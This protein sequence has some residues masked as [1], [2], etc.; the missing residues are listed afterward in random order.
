METAA[1]S[2]PLSSAVKRTLLFIHPYGQLLFILI[3][4]CQFIR[5]LKPLSDLVRFG[6]EGIGKSGVVAEHSSVP[7]RIVRSS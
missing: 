4:L 2:K 3:C 5:V 1:G 7:S 6:G